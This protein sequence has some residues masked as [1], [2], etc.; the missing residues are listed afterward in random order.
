[1]LMSLILVQKGEEE[2]DASDTTSGGFSSASSCEEHDLVDPMVSTRNAPKLHVIGHLIRALARSLMVRL[3]QMQLKTSVGAGLQQATFL[4]IKLVMAEVL[5][6]REHKLAK[7]ME[8]QEL[9]L[10]AMPTCSTSRNEGKASVD[11]M[12]FILDI[13]DLLILQ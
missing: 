8:W 9:L 1:M 13:G 7:L 4:W 3:T 11:H 6:R 12:I 10:A 5:M 2:C